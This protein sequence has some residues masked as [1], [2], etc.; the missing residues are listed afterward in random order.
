M[1]DALI[2]IKPK[3]VDRFLNG[4]KAV[5]IRN[6]KVNLTNNSKLWIYTTLP[7]ASIQTIAYVKYVDIDSPEFIWKKHRESIGISKNSFDK[8]VNGSNKISAIVTKDIRKLPFEITLEEIRNMVPEFQPP[9]FLKF[10]RDDDPILS[11]IL[12]IISRDQQ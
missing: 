2:S 6:R 12:S 3:Y 5:E 8:Y 7:K 11:A 1:P 10:M 9:Q 4:Q